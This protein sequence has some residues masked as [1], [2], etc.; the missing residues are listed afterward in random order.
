MT[1]EI[2]LIG[3]LILGILLGTFFFGGLWLT[4]Q[5]GLNSSKAVFIF[6][7][8]FFIRM[9]ICLGVFFYLSKF[10]WILFCAALIGFQI[11]RIIL[12]YFNQNHHSKFGED[13]AS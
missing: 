6:F 3:F 12:R 7:A 8:S 1:F 5:Y 4:V 13:H 2:K 9:G 11:G 10:D